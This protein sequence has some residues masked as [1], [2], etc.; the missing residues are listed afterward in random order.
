MGPTGLM[1]ALA[2]IVML[3]CTIQLLGE[4]NDKDPDDPD[5]DSA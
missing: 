4:H 1:T 3:I 5:D 2:L